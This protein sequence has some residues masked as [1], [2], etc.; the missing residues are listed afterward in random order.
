MFRRLKMTNV[1]RMTKPKWSEILRLR[2]RH[3]VIWTSFVIWH[4]DFVIPLG[5]QQRQGSNAPFRLGKR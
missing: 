3:S 2:F 4:S 1:E 5:K